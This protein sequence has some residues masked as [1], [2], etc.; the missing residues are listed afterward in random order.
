MKFLLSLVVLCVFFVS[1][2]AICEQDSKF[3]VEGERRFYS[4]DKSYLDSV[5]VNV[6]NKTYEQMY[7][8][9]ME[10][11]MDRF[12][13]VSGILPGSSE[14]DCIQYWCDDGL[15]VKKQLEAGSEC[16]ENGVFRQPCFENRFECNENGRCIQPPLQEETVLD[17][18]LHGYFGG[19]LQN[20][21]K[22]FFGFFDSASSEN[23][24]RFLWDG[25]TLCDSSEGHCPE[26]FLNEHTR[27]T[28]K[29]KIICGV[30]GRYD[31][32][33]VKDGTPCK[34]ENYCAQSYRCDNGE[35]KPK[36]KK[37]CPVNQVCDMH[38]G[39]IPADVLS[40]K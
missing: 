13:F 27:Y 4:D 5:A 37:E 38:V 34:N 39:C 22:S 35:C 19:R 7:L 30:E 15:L 6:G 28:V 20:I 36:Y 2:Q 16:N 17:Y 18:N 23:S 10:C 8:G 40:T 26:Y 25:Y 3:Y 32:L 12:D 11:R 1:C 9:C 29:N 31:I 14:S 21:D 33:T 24:V